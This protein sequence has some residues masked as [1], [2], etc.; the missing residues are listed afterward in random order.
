MYP[1]HDEPLMPNLVFLYLLW[2]GWGIAGGN[3][4]PFQ[5]WKEAIAVVINGAMYGLV[6]SF[7]LIIWNGQRRGTRMSNGASGQRP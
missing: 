5:L 2:P 1:Y 7:L 3:P 6:V 4:L